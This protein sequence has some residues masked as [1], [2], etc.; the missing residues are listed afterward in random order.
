MYVLHVLNIL[1]SAYVSKHNSN[2]EKQVNL[3]MIPSGEGWYYL[4]VKNKLSALLREK[5]TEK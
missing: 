4:A 3:L 1:C 2:S 5:I